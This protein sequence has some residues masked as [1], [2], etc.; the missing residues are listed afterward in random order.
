M[1]LP[2]VITGEA[3]ADF[4]EAAQWYEAKSAGLGIDLV[5]QVRATIN[6]AAANPEAYAKIHGDLRRAPVK[7]LRYGVFYRL[8]DE[9]LYV[10]AVLHDRRD[11]TIWQ[12]RA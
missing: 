6:F 8:S 2:V 7:R 1:S 10:V 11:P 4:D 12:S 5:A 9:Q 3:E